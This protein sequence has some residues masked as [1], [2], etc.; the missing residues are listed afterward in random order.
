[1]IASLLGGGEVSWLPNER[2]I[3]RNANDVTQ[4]TTRGARNILGDRQPKEAGLM[5][6][7]L[8]GSRSIGIARADLKT[9][10]DGFPTYPSDREHAVLVD[11]QRV[12]VAWGNDVSNHSRGGE[13]FWI[14]G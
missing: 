7:R 14:V 2:L 6:M 12:A 10:R 4:V 9:V 8:S 3:Q 5:A 11:R 1:M 13:G